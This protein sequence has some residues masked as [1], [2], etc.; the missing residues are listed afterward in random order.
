METTGPVS[1]RQK[2]QTHKYKETHMLIE[3]SKSEGIMYKRCLF[4]LNIPIVLWNSTNFCHPYHLKTQ[5][6]RWTFKIAE[7]AEAKAQGKY[8]VY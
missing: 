3:H 2:G 7:Y 1:A 4:L 5:R 6:K 8:W